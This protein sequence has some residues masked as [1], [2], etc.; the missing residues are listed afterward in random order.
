MIG[1]SKSFLILYQS[2]FSFLASSNSLPFSSAFSSSSLFSSVSY[3][4]F[5]FWV[6][7][8]C[9]ISDSSLSHSSFWTVNCSIWESFCSTDYVSLEII[10]SY[11]PIFLYRPASYSCSSTCSWS[12]AGGM[13]RGLGLLQGFQGFSCWSNWSHNKRSRSI[14]SCWRIP[15]WLETKDFWEAIWVTRC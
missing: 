15:L 5:C 14:S 11:L 12:W 10:L 9:Y 4:Y 8:M 2:V 6:S 1:F 3:S 13:G 7:Y